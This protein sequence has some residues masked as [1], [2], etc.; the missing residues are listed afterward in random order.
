MRVGQESH[1]RPA[2]VETHSGGSGGGGR[3]LHRPLCPTLAVV[4]RRRLSPGVG[5]HRGIHWGRRGFRGRSS[6]C[7]ADP[8]RGRKHLTYGLIRR[9]FLTEPVRSARP[10]ELRM[11]RGKRLRASRCAPLGSPRVL[12]VLLAD[13]TCASRAIERSNVGWTPSW[14]QVNA[15]IRDVIELPIASTTGSSGSSAS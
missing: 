10:I 15:P 4:F 6:P 9:L 8:I 5:G 2:G 12:V 13:D 14:G 11:L 7:S 1:R 3:H